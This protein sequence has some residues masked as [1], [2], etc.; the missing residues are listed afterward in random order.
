MIRSISILFFLIIFSSPLM[1]QY[2]FTHQLRGSHIE[3][4]YYWSLRPTW[5]FYSPEFH[6]AGLSV[7]HDGPF[8]PGTSV[9]VSSLGTSMI[10]G[11]G[12]VSWMWHALIQHAE[13]PDGKMKFS[14]YVIISLFAPFALA[15]T[16][17]HLRF[18]DTRASTM[19]PQFCMDLLIGNRTDYYFGQADHFWRFT[20]SF[21]M[22][23]SMSQTLAYDPG[24]PNSTPPFVRP[25][26]HG[27]G[28]A[29]G[30]DKYIDI[31]EGKSHYRALE[32]YISLRYIHHVN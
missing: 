19:R 15:N 23:I 8:N 5:A 6:I 21:G 16:E 27:I 32:P 12:A 7:L 18:I 11:I 24:Q 22:E 1:A 14:E 4:A 30:F 31:N 20:P 10:A 3:S 25:K 2:G 17:H 29:F 9:S 13:D 26:R 28:L